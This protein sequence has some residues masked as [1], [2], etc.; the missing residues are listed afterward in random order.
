M[1]KAY[2]L[3]D[4][5][6]WNINDKSNHNTTSCCWKHKELHEQ[7]YCWLLYR[8]YDDFG[9]N[10]KDIVKIKTICFDID[11]SYQYKDELN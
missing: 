1:C 11:V 7:K 5:R 3:E 10:W 8:L 6:Y 4:T 2:F 9:I